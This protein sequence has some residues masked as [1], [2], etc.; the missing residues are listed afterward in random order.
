[1]TRLRFTLLPPATKLQE[2]NVFT[3]VCDSVHKGVSA[4][5]GLCPRGSLLGELGPVSVMVT[6]GRY[7][8]YWNAFLSGENVFPE[9]VKG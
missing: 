3:P 9:L 7:A 4:Q 8:S 5:G 2:G 1:M 6:C